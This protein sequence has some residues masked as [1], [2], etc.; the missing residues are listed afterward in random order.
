[1]HRELHDDTTAPR[2]AAVRLKWVHSVREPQ[3]RKPQVRV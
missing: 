2:T 1:M 3:A